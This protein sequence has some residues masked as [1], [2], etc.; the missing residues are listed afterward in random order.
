MTTLFHLVRHAEHGHVGAVLTGRLP[1]AGL[2][3]KGRAQAAALA[4]R[5]GRARIDA[6]LTSPQGRAVVTAGFI[7]ATIGTAPRIA[8]ELDEIDF[9]RWQ[10]QSFD[11]LARDPAWLRWNAE[12]DRA[13]TPAGDSMGAV[14][15]RLVALLDGLHR[16][17]PGGAVALVSHS[18]VIKAGLCHYRGMP[19]RTVHDFEIAPA[20]VTTLSLDQRGA[21]IIAVNQSADALEEAIP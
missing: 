9:G 8:G 1:G 17:H 10:G 11:A 2:T 16:S 3:P 5:M 15:R 4:R 7:A 18:D 19:F 12:R 13:E 14:A 21:T 6:L 20:S